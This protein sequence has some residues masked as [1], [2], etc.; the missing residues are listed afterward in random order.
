MQIIATAL[1]NL[2][3]KRKNKIKSFLQAERRR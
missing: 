1:L 2:H 3:A